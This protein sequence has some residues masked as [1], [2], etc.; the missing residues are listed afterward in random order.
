MTVHTG[1]S[2]LTLWRGVP[3]RILNRQRAA[4]SMSIAMLNDH[5][6][7]DAGYV[8]DDFGRIVRIA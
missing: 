5:L 8:R 3:A 2:L 6:L 7:K 4:N 1:R